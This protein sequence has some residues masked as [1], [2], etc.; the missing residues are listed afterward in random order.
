MDFHIRLILPCVYI[1]SRLFLAWFITSFSFRQ[2]YG[3]LFHFLWK[4]NKNVITKRFWERR[5]LSISLSGLLK[6][7]LFANRE[8][9]ICIGSAFVYISNCKTKILFLSWWALEAFEMKAEQGARRPEINPSRK[10][11]CSLLPTE[12]YH[13]YHKPTWKRDDGPIL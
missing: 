12:P 2:L 11:I 8:F 7:C 13:M 4:V 1:S 6:K 9:L 5:L 10:R 3:S